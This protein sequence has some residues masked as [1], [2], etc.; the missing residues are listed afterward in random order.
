MGIDG[1]H[2]HNPVRINT[3]PTSWYRMSGGYADTYIHFKSKQVFKFCYKY[4]TE[5]GMEKTTPISIS[6]IHYSTVC[7]LVFSKV[8]MG[9]QGFPRLLSYEIGDQQIKMEMDYLGKT[10]HDACQTYS[11]HTRWA[12][13]PKLLDYLIRTNF[14]L[15]Y[16][17]IQ[18]TDI[19]LGN[20][21][22]DSQDNFHLIDFNCMSVRMERRWSPA[23]GTWHYVAPEILMTGEPLEN[24]M[25]WSI[26]MVMTHWLVG[27]YPISND[28]MK[29]YIQKVSTTQQDWRRLMN[30]IRK[31]YP[32]VLQLEHAYTTALGDWWPKL[33][34]LLRWNPYKRWNL[35]R[36]FQ[37]NAPA[38][39]KPQIHVRNL[40]FPANPLR[41]PEYIRER[42]LVKGLR[43][44]NSI[45]MEW[46]FVNT[47]S[48]FDRSFPC[49]PEADADADAK[50]KANTLSPDLW[51]VCCWA[52]QGYLTNDF[53]FDRDNL[54]FAV[55]S[56]FHLT[57]DTVM[58]HI[59]TVLKACDSQA[60]QKEWYLYLPPSVPLTGIQW[61]RVAYLLGCIK[62]LYTPESIA[63]AYV[64]MTVAGTAAEP[65]Q[66][67]TQP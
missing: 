3:L 25:T 43:F 7:D 10:L 12:L 19:K 24:S 65:A 46:F 9:L 30:A 50:H 20:I 34:P 53:L 1:G 22:I 56:H 58:N 55:H 47:M 17:G 31:K 52:I 39:M 51:F 45:H 42:I 16:N 5:E 48:L 40:A 63:N 28:R 61:E 57:C 11:K 49:E 18:H 8:L 32:D 33:Q 67:E 21:L 29:R 4:F 44:L 54:V 38:S 23:I 60:W 14:N 37:M 26:G 2:L 27:E 13:A 6:I 66:S 62:E 36:L 59:Y 41:I 15:W 35:E 64:N